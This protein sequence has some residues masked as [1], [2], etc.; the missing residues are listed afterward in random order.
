MTQGCHTPECLQKALSFH[1]AFE[2]EGD[3]RKA[4]LGTPCSCEK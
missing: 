2:K 3:M 1:I 4:D